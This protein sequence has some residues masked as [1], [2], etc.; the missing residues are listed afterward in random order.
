M[1]TNE[2]SG[3]SWS[4]AFSVERAFRHGWFAKLGYTY[5]VSRNTVDAGSI[6]N[7]S[8]TGNPI[9][10]DP[11]NPQAAY[12]QFSPGHR[13]FAAVTY[14]RDFTGLGPTS[15]SVYFEGRSTGN[16]SYVFS[17]DMNGDGASG[18]DLIYVPRNTSEMNFVTN[19]VKVGADSII[20]T[21]AQQAAAWEAFIEQDSYLRSRR[22]AYAERNA[23]F[24]PMVYR[25]DVSISQDVGR[26]IAGR[27]NQLEI[28]LD[29]LNFTNLLNKNWGVAQTFV[30]NRPLTFAGVDATGA[31]TYRLA[32]NGLQLISQSFTKSV[33]TTDVWRMQLG[34]RYMLNW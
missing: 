1:L 14:S 12:S 5:G 23:V 2:N 32:N 19:K 6:A 3:Y 30:T 10:L 15:V 17:G 26:R 22:G 8:W 24:L 28:R 9:F 18:N 16:G 4:L 21:P 25:A 31:A 11:N 34:V 29:I 33:L 27:P 13:V 7:G 20:Y